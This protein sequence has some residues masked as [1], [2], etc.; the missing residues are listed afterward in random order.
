MHS[1]T[2]IHTE[3]HPLAGKWVRI[4][5]GDL[6]GQ[7]IHVEDWWDRVYGESWMTAQGNPACLKYAVRTACQRDC[8]PTDNEVIYGKI[9]PYGVLVHVCE[10]GEV[11][12]TPGFNRVQ[13]ERFKRLLPGFPR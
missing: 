10:L 7:I 4:A 9:S 2:I 12:Q 8:T 11:V 5:R 6:A 13:H 1:T 3:Q